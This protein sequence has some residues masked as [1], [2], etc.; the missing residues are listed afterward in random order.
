MEFGR[1]QW[2]A[3]HEKSVSQWP[4]RPELTNP[5]K[6]GRMKKAPLA[7]TEVGPEFVEHFLSVTLMIT[8]H[9]DVEVQRLKAPKA[10]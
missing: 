10:V 3:R 7:L 6:A 2:L 8:K 9:F 5:P 1:S 4:T